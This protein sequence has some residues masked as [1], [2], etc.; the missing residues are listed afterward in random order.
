MPVITSRLT[1]VADGATDPESDPARDGS[2]RFRSFDGGPWW[3]IRSRRGGLCPAGGFYADNHNQPL[4]V[5]LLR[6]R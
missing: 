4:S 1:G 6:G 3:L 2:P 5:P